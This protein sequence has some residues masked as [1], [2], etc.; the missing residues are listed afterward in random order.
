MCGW[1]RFSI[2]LNVRII[3]NLPCFTPFFQFRPYHYAFRTSVERINYLPFTARSIYNSNLY[4]PQPFQITLIIHLI[5]KNIQPLKVI[6]F[7]KAN[8]QVRVGKIWGFRSVASI[9]PFSTSEECLF[10]LPQECKL[11]L[12][13][14]ALLLDEKYTILWLS[15]RWNSGLLCN[16]YPQATVAIIFIL[17]VNAPIFH[18]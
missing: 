17:S 9:R 14:H 16:I 13:K 1:P 4:S 8:N 2:N 5:I 10:I 12:V 18:I 11:S 3:P 6:Y 7:T 15:Q